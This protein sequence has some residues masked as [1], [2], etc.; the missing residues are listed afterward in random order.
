MHARIV[1]LLIGILLLGSC[2]VEKRLYNRGWH[3]EFRKNP[4]R[5]EKQ[6]EARAVAAEISSE[7]SSIETDTVLTEITDA[8]LPDQLS[9]EIVLSTVLEKRKPPIHNTAGLQRKGLPIH[10]FSKSKNET[11]KT[12]RTWSQDDKRA[13][14]ILVGIL[15]ILAIVGII[16]LLIQFQVAA[17][18]GESLG[19]LFLLFVVGIVGIILLF[20]LIAMSFTSSKE[21]VRKKEMEKARE[22]KNKED[23]S[24]EE[25]DRYEKQQKASDRDG[26]VAAGF[27]VIVLLLILG[28]AVLS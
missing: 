9:D 3:V 22:E 6:H 15:L 5:S 25:K 19:L 23:M 1:F 27:V 11:N 28:V 18:L 20:T 4:H 13:S 26:K 24:D 16:A 10:A 2:T 14:M 17:T 8:A 12:S 7:R 21:E